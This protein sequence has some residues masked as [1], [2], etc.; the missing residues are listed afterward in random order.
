MAIGSLE[1]RGLGPSVIALDEMA[2]S[3]NVTFAGYA[4]F[5]GLVTVRVTGDLSAV[6]QAI[7]AGIRAA[8]QVGQVVAA[9]VIAKIPGNMGELLPETAGELAIGPGSAYFMAPMG[10]AER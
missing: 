5:D 2:K 9:K 4:V 7:D 1:T 6:R 8:S 10:K 3:A